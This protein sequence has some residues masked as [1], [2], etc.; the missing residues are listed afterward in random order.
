MQPDISIEH[1]GVIKYLDIT[2]VANDNKLEEAYKF[3]LTRYEKLIIIPVVIKYNGVLYPKS[4][5]LL[6][7][8]NI[9]DKTWS[10]L[11]SNTYGAISRNWIDAEKNC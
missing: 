5:E 9:D 6:R 11:H 2:Y 7:K 4:L 3:K 8:L 10:R 1:E